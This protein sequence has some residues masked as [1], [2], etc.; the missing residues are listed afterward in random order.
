MSA[1]VPVDPSLPV[2]PPRRPRRTD[3]VGSGRKGGH[4]R[5]ISEATDN[6]RANT[7]VTSDNGEIRKFKY[8]VA[9]PRKVGKVRGF[10]NGVMRRF[11]QDPPGR[12]DKSEH[13]A[14]DSLSGNRRR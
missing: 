7:R 13:V 10:V 1:A 12:I 4:G 11:H 5:E 14:A 2:R 8:D 9:P 6:W 3:L